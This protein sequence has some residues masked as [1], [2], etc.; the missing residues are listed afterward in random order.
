MP[1]IDSPRISDLIERIVALTRSPQTT[2]FYR[3]AV[4]A[5]GGGLV[6]W[7]AVRAGQMMLVTTLIVVP[8]GT[9][10][11]SWSRRPPSLLSAASVGV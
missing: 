2:P 4:A 6:R 9:R 8:I 3:R 10:C 7:G 5:L 1:H 11:V